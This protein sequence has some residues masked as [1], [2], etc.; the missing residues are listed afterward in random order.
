[1]ITGEVLR[2]LLELRAAL[3]PKGTGEA[4]GE[5]QASGQVAWPWIRLLSLLLPPI[6]SSGTSQ[7]VTQLASS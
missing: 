4:Q 3:R 5:G 7:L 1:M 6:S 2:D